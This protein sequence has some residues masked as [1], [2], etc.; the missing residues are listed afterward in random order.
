MDPAAKDELDA[1]QIGIDAEISNIHNEQNQS[2]EAMRAE[3][4]AK[5]RRIEEQTKVQIQRLQ[6]EAS[7]KTTEIHEAT[8]KDLGILQVNSERKTQELE[9]KRTA[10]KR[11]HE[12]DYQEIESEFSMRLKSLEKR[13]MPSST[14]SRKIRHH[15]LM[16]NLFKKA[17]QNAQ[18]KVQQ[19]DDRTCYPFHHCVQ[20][21]TYPLLKSPTARTHRHHLAKNGALRDLQRMVA[22]HAEVEFGGAMGSDQYAANARQM[23]SPAFGL[24]QSLFNLNS[25]FFSPHVSTP[26][27]L[28]YVAEPRF[29]ARQTERN[30][31]RSNSLTVPRTITFEE[32]FENVRREDSQEKH[33]I[34]EFP[35]DSSKWYILRCDEHD[36]NFGEYPFSSARCHIDSDAH[37]HISRTYENC[38][39]KL[40]VLVLGCTS[41]RAESNNE[42]Y[43]KALQG[44][45]KPKQGNMKLRKHRRTGRVPNNGAIGK[46]PHHNGPRPAGLFKPFEGIV[47]PDPGEVYQGAQQKP[48][49]VE[50]QWCLVVCLP[51]RNW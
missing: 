22:L 37:G 51:L 9:D 33:F 34:V 47:N 17:Q 10:R 13:C 27:Q 14:N 3:A 38:I 25:Q 35:Q 8:K 7:R 26:A 20:V 44:G 28:I 16:L 2:A 12:D 11:K 1:A 31:Q 23:D 43:K 5:I 30:V 15:R 32:V 6:D 29:L 48:G 41:K 42:V 46:K 19:I 36:M 49:R 18:Q 21:R 40:G 4:D 39:L 45:Y 50:P 24:S